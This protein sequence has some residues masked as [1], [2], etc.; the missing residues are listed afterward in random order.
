MPRTKSKRVKIPNGAGS[1]IRRSD[2]RYMARYTTTDPDTGLSV[3]KAL[4]GATE[5]EARAKL[6]AALAARQDGRLILTR[7]RPLTLKQWADQWIVSRHKRPSTMKTDREVLDLHILPTL[8]KVRLVDLRPVHI[9]GVMEAKLAEG[10]SPRTCNKVREVARKVLNAVNREQPGYL[11]FNVAE[12]VE[13]VPQLAVRRPIVLEPTQVHRLL[14]KTR[15][16]RDGCFWTFVLATAA[17]LGEGLGLCWEDVD[18]D[19]GSV[20][21]RRELQY[22]KGV[23]HVLPPKTRKSERPI[24]LAATA[25]EALRREREAQ[26]DRRARAGRAWDTEYGDLVFTTDLGRPLDPSN[27]R[28]RLYKVEEDLKLPKIGPHQLGRHGCASFLAD[29][30]VPPAVAMAILG[31]ANFSTTM[32][33]YTHALPKSMREAA[34]AIQR[35]LTP[36]ERAGQ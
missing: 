20:Y 29:Q 27:L 16:H 1:V 28:R 13:P 15:E 35:A 6:I 32:E 11:A 21:I 36:A 26:A 31:H 22:L 23:W 30:N 7:G 18:L 17:R 14:A 34:E 4:Y 12:L 5:Q 25:C 8:G 33:V 9:R 10:K 3:R 24:P 2:G 19:D